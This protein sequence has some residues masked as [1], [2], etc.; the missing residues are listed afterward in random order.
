M[1][2]RLDQSRK[3]MSDEAVKSL[4]NTDVVDSL[5]IQLGSIRFERSAPGTHGVHRVTAVN[6]AGLLDVRFMT[7]SST[8]KIVTARCGIPAVGLHSNEGTEAPAS[9]KCST[10]SLTVDGGRKVSPGTGTPRQ[11]RTC[12]FSEVDC[13]AEITLSDASC[14]FL[15]GTRLAPGRS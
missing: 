5:P 13:K 2:K 1:D 7:G 11:R 15:A 6:T 14:Q 12:L 3:A 10:E 9:C 4:D 8:Q